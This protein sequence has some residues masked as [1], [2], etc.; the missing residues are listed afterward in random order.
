MG[1]EESIGSEFWTL[2]NPTS[3]PT[4]DFMGILHNNIF[5]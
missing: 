3:D 1:R 4:I 2:N 5:K